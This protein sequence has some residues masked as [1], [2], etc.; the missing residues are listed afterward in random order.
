LLGEVD[1][2]LQRIDEELQQMETEDEQ[3]ETSQEEWEDLSI[4][5]FKH[6]EN[7]EKEVLRTT[8]IEMIE[9]EIREKLKI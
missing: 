6:C 9:D 2:D 4:D 8:F 5:Q 3:E 1:E 7:D